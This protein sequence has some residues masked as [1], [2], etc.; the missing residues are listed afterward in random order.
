MDSQRQILLIALGVILLLLWFRWEDTQ[1][2]NA[3]APGPAAVEQRAVS[4]GAPSAPAVPAAKT[5]QTGAPRVTAPAQQEMASGKRIRVLTDLLDVQIDTYGGDL[6][7]LGLRKHPK[8]LNNPDVPF[9]LMQDKGDEILVAQSGLVGHGKYYPFHRT[10]FTTNSTSHTL[11]EGQDS[12]SVDLNWRAKDGVRYTKRYTFKRNSYVVRVDFL[13]DNRSRAEWQGFFYGQFLK[14]PEKKESGFMSLPTF[15]GGV[16]YTREN[17]YEKIDYDE[18]AEEPLKRKV[19]GGW[20]AMMQPYFV[21]SWLPAAEQ[22]GQI[23][24]SSP[25]PQ[26]YVIGYKYTEPLIVAPGKSAQVGI[27]LFA[28]PKETDRLKPLAEGM[29]LTVDFGWLTFISAPLYW[30]LTAINSYIGNLGVSI[31]VL[32]I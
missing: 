5:G 9:P 13:V 15:D 2:A 8:E 6:R 26:H 18:L 12:L 3:P 28:G 20:A 11:R 19:V 30:L 32:T 4:G 27:D 24:S 25:S 29:D 31:I 16:I 14:K 22:P 17:Q 10:R 23:Y 1:R 21:S 7:F